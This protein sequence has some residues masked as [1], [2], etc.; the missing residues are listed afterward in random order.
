MPLGTPAVSGDDLGVNNVYASKMR[1]ERVVRS[2][3]HND[4]VC[5][6]MQQILVNE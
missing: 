3:E 6:M 4:S 5:I 2:E 1:G